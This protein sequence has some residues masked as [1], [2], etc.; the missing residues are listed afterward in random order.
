MGVYDKRKAFK[1]YE[2]PEVLKFREAIKQSRWDIEEFNLETDAFD[3][4]HKLNRNEQELIK[5]ALL[6]ISQIE[7]SVKTFWSKLGDYLQ[8]PEFSSVGIT[9]AENEI[10]HAEALTNFGV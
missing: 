5:R 4:K 1:P 3:F 6:A 9:F 7:I 8:K 2:Y 10:V